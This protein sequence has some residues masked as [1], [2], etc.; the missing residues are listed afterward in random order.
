MTRVE[1]PNE[2]IAY[3][4]SK[5]IGALVNACADVFVEN[6]AKI[7]EGKMQGSLI[8]N[9]SLRL[10]TGY[11]KCSDTAWNKI[12]HSQDVVEIELAGNQI[13]TYLLDRLL[14]AVINPKKNS[15]QLLLYKVPLQ[16]ETNAPTLFGKIQSVLDHISAMTDVYALDLFRKLNGLSLPAI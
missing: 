6:E 9:I 3:L 15:S 5:I 10:N 1:D 13:I 14:D 4:R 12:Y 11:K 16:Y 8:D 7:L 2:K